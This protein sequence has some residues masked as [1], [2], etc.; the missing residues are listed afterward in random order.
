MTSVRYGA[1]FNPI[2]VFLKS[3]LIVCKVLKFTEKGFW[4]LFGTSSELSQLSPEKWREEGINK[5]SFQ[6]SNR[7]YCKFCIKFSDLRWFFFQVLLWLKK[8]PVKWRKDDMDMGSTAELVPNFMTNGRILSK[9]IFTKW[10]FLGSIFL[11]SRIFQKIVLGN[12]VKMVP[13]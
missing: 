6:L 7:K 3:R 9:S 12:D 4:S 5:V 11:I 8:I 10:S 2:I 1:T 13:T